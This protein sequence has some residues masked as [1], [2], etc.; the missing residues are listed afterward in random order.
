MAT[1]R[2]RPT[3]IYPS[4]NAG[5]VVFYEWRDPTLSENKGWSFGD[6]HP[7]QSKHRGYRLVY[8]K[9]ENEE[10]REQWF[11]AKEWT[12]QENHNWRVSYPY[13][14]I[15]TCPRFACTFIVPRDSYAPEAKGT[16]HPLDLGDSTPVKNYRFRGAKLISETQV[17]T[18][19]QEIDNLFMAVERVYDRVPD[20]AEQ[21]LVNI[22]TSFPHGGLKAYPR[23]VRTLIY[24][25]QSFT[26]ITKGTADPVFTNAV[27][28]D[29]S[30]MEIGDEDLKSLYVAVRRVYD[31]VPTIAAQESY[32]AEITYPYFGDTRFPRTTRTY[33]VPRA[34]LGAAVIPSA[35]L[36]LGGATLAFRK[37]DR[38]AAQPEDSYYVVVT[39]AHDRIPLASE[40]SELDFLKGFGYGVTR[41]YGADDYPRV[42]WR[43]PAVKAG[44]VLTPEYAA[45]PVVGYTSLQLTDESL[46]ADPNNAS[47]VVVVR[48]Y[49]TLPGPELEAEERERFVSV[50]EGFIVE[51]RV[52]TLRQPVKNN[53]TITALETNA[54][55]DSGGTLTQTT[56][57]MDTPSTVVLGKGQTRLTLTVG[58]LTSV[59]FDEE[60][61]RLY[62]VTREIVP[63]G[64]AGSALNGGGVFSTV[65]A[66]NQEYSIKTTR[67]ATTL[68][69]GEISYDTVVNWGWPA[70]L[71]SIRFGVIEYRD[72]ETGLPY[73]GRGVYDYEMKEG[74]AGPCRATITET[75]SS[76]PQAV[77]SITPLIPRGMDFDF[78]LT[79]RFSVPE[80][81]HPSFTV[82]ETVGSN[83]PELMP[84]VSSK[85]FAATNYTDWPASVIAS[86]SQTPYRGGYKMRVMRVYAPS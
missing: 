76:T 37:V 79:R 55:T 40:V 10:G 1:N 65:D 80:C 86:V 53:A 5:D 17:S 43:V 9:A 62:N 8:V 29:E 59:E 24:P 84:I 14:G 57:A 58:P 71:T 48:V 68:V 12:D 31:E 19:F 11:Y 49:D 60:T 52:E 27:L 77:P 23:R 34:N 45:C 74:Y 63:A 33:L 44:F 70:V 85:T 81:L 82:A 28:I 13:A 67:K 16:A 66:L 41:P 46:E 51:K 73:F 30:Q 39:V 75:W 20:E 54:P 6:L 42:T 64:T 18:G 69:D 38:L 4:P 61:G 47:N 22:E 35:G 7:N 78:P 36:S 15:T 72:R 25:R 26:P 50:P 56:L 32:N 21:L 3:N 2:W 83:H